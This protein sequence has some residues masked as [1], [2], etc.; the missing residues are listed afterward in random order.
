MA[1][2]EILSPDDMLNKLSQALIQ[3]SRGDPLVALRNE[4]Q[5]Q[6][7][8][9]ETRFLAIDKAT[10][11]QHEDMVRV[12]TQVD[13]AII[14]LQGLLEQRMETHAE[15]ILG[16]LMTQTS[17]T[18]EKFAGIKQ[19]F[20]GSDTA[21]A[22]AFKGNKDLIDAQNKANTDAADKNE[23]AFKEQI[24]A[25]T[26]FMNASFSGMT[27]QNNASFASLNKQVDDLKGL[28]SASAGATANSNKIMSVI[29][30]AVA[31]LAAL[32]ATVIHVSPPAV[33]VYVAAPSTSGATL[34]QPK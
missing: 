30:L 34:I 24:L 16:N 33:P 17:E 6:F 26:T 31:I 9:I 22:A 32:Y 25:L 1:D 20:S 4:L 8:A 2:Q 3:V 29:G 14:S 12:P 23:K 27:T 21:L 7:R 11:L 19:Q 10:E 18:A 13:K 28:A 5:T 15:K